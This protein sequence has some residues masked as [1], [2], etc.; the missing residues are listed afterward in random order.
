MIDLCS[1]LGGAS[2][3]FFQNGWK[4]HRFDNNK[5]FSD[6][7]SENYVPHT[8]Y[9]DVTK[10]IPTMDCDFL[11]ASPPCYQF[12]LAYDAPRPRAAREGRPFKP[13]MTILEKI[14][15][16][17][18]RINP[19]YWAIENV[20]GAGKY[21]SEYLGPCR[22]KLGAALLWGNFPLVGF[23]EVDARWKYKNDNSRARYSPIRSN[24]IAKL[25]YW[26]SDQLRVSASSLKLE[27]F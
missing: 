12:S 16:Y 8:T 24:I 20:V 13:D 26:I 5:I 18:D 21:F 9:C 2:E 3:A 27:D 7:Q 14:I 17:R 22:I 4:V 6:P 23:K 1:G 25:P 19:R 15:E 10:F 11:F